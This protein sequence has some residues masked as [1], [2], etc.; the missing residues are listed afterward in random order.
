MSV[1]RFGSRAV[2]LEVSL[3]EYREVFFVLSGDHTVTVAS[4]ED[5][6]PGQLEPQ[7]FVFAKPYGWTTDMEAEDLMT[8]VW[9]VVGVQ[10]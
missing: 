2:A 9:Q 1:T 6:Q 5:D 4:I 8:Q 10:R 7:V 3:G